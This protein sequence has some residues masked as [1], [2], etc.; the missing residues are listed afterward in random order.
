MDTLHTSVSNLTP[1]ERLGSLMEDMLPSVPYL[2]GS[3]NPAV[4]IKETD[5]DFQF[6]VEA[7]GVNREN[8]EV[9]LSGDVLV[10]RGKREEVKEEKDGFIRRERFQGAFYRSF[11]LDAPVKEHEI[12]ASYAD[13]ILTVR[14]PKAEPVKTQRV[15]IN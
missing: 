3:W 1:L 2:R 5:E 12:H 9:E 14:V 15:R 13:G 7:P 11:R 6:I 10:I 4:D 8:M